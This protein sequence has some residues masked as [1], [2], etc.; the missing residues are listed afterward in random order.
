M[1]T[2]L[3]RDRFVIAPSTPEAEMEEQLRGIDNDHSPLEA[4]TMTIALLRS[5]LSKGLATF[6]ATT[7]H[8]DPP[9]CLLLPDLPTISK[10]KCVE[11]LQTIQC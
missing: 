8:F 10:Q 9:F 6:L 1:L 11:R 7:L 4:L 2:Y 5:E 3:P